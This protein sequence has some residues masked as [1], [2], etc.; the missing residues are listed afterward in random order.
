MLLLTRPSE[1]HI[2]ALLDA[3]RQLPFSYAEVGAADGAPPPGYA[4]D[5]SR[6]RLGAG[7]A[8]FERGCAALRGWEHIPSGWMRLL[9]PDVP[10]APEA[11]VGVLV[12]LPGLWALSACRV[13]YLIDEHEP[14]R[15]FGFGWGTLPAH[16]ARGEERFVVEWRPDDS[17][18]YDIV[19]FSRPNHP[20][21][22][23]GYPAM[24]LM[25]RRFARDSM[26]AMVRAVS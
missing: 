15:R 17:V 18:W 26:R 21:L 13:A 2:R 4:V 11:T 12:G 10:L 7:Q 24:R 3:Q 25:Q 9:W 22:R 8:V 16:V 19:A 5:R 6:T 1:A 14:A 23:L 20:L